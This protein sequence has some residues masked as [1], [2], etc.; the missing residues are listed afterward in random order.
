MV[1]FDLALQLLLFCDGLTYLFI[2]PQGPLI[3]VYSLDLGATEAQYSTLS[4]LRS[5]P[6][7]FKLAF[8]F[9]SDNFPIFGYRRKSFMMLGW[10]MAS[11]SMG[12]LLLVSDLSLREEEFVD[13]QGGIGKRVVAPE[14]APS[15]PLLS[16]TTLLFGTGFW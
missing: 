9:L 4:S 1:G 13:E 3:N 2:I 8:G 15:I 6:A 12:F 5:L 16:L 14:N 11:L 7:T 10:L